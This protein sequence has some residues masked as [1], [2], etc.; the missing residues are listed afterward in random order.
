MHTGPVIR[1]AVSTELVLSGARIDRGRPMREQIYAIVRLLIL[2]GKLA[3]GDQ[4]DEKAIA[5]ELS[6]SRTP[7]REAVKKLSD[8]GL[9]EVK[10]QSGTLVSK[11]LR[12]QIHEAFL[13]RRA[14]EVE[15]VGHAA[16]RMSEAGAD[17]LED[18][19]LLH[20]RAIERRKFVEAIGL[21]DAFHRT[22]SEIADLPLLWHTVDISKAQLDR[23]RYLTLPQAGHGAATLEQ[24]RGILEALTARDASLARRMMKAHLEQAY[25]GILAFLDQSGIA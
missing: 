6:V 9:V 11:L 4:I 8:E 2:S 23:C 18:V 10:A 25:A 19:F 3:P 17:R 20:K 13:I 16:G 1:Q 24:H 12:K 22:I 5:G 14:L 15:G 7:V 21:D